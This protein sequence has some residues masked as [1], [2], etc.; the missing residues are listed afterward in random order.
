[1][2]AGSAVLDRNYL[3]D[4]KRVKLYRVEGDEATVEDPFCN[5][6]KV[7]ISELDELPEKKEK[8]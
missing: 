6:Y 4:G 3:H 5:F 7:D 8:K 1:M 2:L